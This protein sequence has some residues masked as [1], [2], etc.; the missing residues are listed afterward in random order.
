MPVLN[1]RRR[2]SLRWLAAAS[3]AGALG[4]SPLATAAGAGQT[5][6]VLYRRDTNNAPG[7]QDVAAQAAASALEDEFAKQNYRVVQ[8]T[9]EAYAILDQ[10]PDVIVTFDP[11]AGFSMLFSVVRESRQMPNADTSWAEVRIQARVF[12]G[13]SVLVA[14]GEAEGVGRMVVTVPGA[15]GERRGFEQAARKAAAELVP[16]VVRRLREIS[17]ADIAARSRP[18]PTVLASGQVV[19]QP[20]PQASAAAPGPTGDANE[21]LPAPKRKFALMVGVSDYSRVSSRLGKVNDLA[22][23][24]RDLENVPAAL[25]RLGFKS[26]NIAVLANAEATSGAVRVRLME[27]AAKCEPDDLVLVAFSCHGGPANLTPSG[28]GLPVLDDFNGPKDQ[29][30]IDFWQIQGLI[31][32]LPARQAVLVVDTC[33]AGGVAFRM[34]RLSVQAGQAPKLSAGTV[35]P[36]PARMVA[37]VANP[38]RHYAILAA[39][40]PEQL[41]QDTPTGGS[42]I[43]HLLQ[44][45]TTTRGQAPLSTVFREHVEK[46]VIE[47]ARSFCKSNRQ[48]DEQS[49]VFA[50]SGQGHMIRIA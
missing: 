5:V 49:P 37:D 25:R 47:Y 26:E 28:Y 17:P 22:G 32:N 11:D 33:H 6:T 27:L 31:A 38:S 1:V 41:S 39:S 9:A 46:Q 40:Q 16:R 15:A 50:Y 44:G 7:R 36:E 43:N 2:D 19:A 20:R 24:K 13:P 30:A 21:P 34:P 23:V 4:P 10:G 14:G 29:N 45:L 8:P 35:S 48:C 12:I 18:V 3:A 42:F